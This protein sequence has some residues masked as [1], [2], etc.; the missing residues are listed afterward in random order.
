MLNTTIG[1]EISKGK[2]QKYEIKTHSYMI[3]KQMNIYVQM[4]K[5]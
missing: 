3:V 2:K 1:L 5:D 4:E